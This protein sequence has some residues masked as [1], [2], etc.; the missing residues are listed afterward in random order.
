MRKAFILLV[1]ISACISHAQQRLLDNEEL[2]KAGAPLSAVASM[3]G[4]PLYPYLQYRA[5]R[6]NLA[7]TPSS[8]ISTFLRAHPTA[9]FSGWL[10]ERAFPHWLSS[11]QYQTIIE[12]YDP[13]FAD[14]SIECE[15]RLAQLA[16]GNQ[17]AA[18]NGINDLWQKASSIEAACDPLFA[19]AV[20]SGKLTSADIRNR[21]ILTMREGN[22]G[23][24]RHISTMLPSDG[25]LAANIWLSIVSGNAPY[26]Q[27]MTITD[28]FWQQSALVNALS[29]QAFKD[30]NRVASMAFELNKPGIADPDLEA[31]LYNRLT[32]ALASNNDPRATQ[33]WARIPADM[34]EDNTAYDMV[35]YFLRRGD[36]QSIVATF[37]QGLASKDNNPEINYWVGKAYEKLGNQRNSQTYYQKAANKRDFFGFLAAEKLGQSY[38]FN[39]HS[40]TRDIGIEQALLSEPEAYRMRIFQN[41]G[42][43]SRAIN[44]WKSLIKNKTNAQIRQAAL[45]ADKY[46]WHIHAISTLAKEKDWDA[47]NVRFP[48]DYEARVRAL[49]TKHALSPATIYAIIR[50]ESIFQPTIKSPAG[51]LGLMQV[52]PA[53]ARD[54][55]RRYNIPYGGTSQ[56]TNVDTNLTIGSQ[57]LADRLREFGH[58]GYAA[59]AYNAGPHRARKW[60]AEY[61]NLPLDEWIAQIPFNETRDYVKRVL[62][63]EKVYQ[64]RLGLNYTPY[65]SA[66]VRAW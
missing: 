29:R 25:I 6:D 44:E 55:A 62:E 2:V 59:A 53:T 33:T 35:A 12:T 23:V 3:Q 14:E 48:T 60:L 37:A 32:R 15:Y 21:F 40:I 13:R 47:L 56:L 57:Y 66:T 1:S 64:Y 11:R 28:P 61:P 27:A 54:T 46:G 9:P 19:A 10:A 65:S 38:A 31:Q 39:D 16:S 51:A 5:Y 7:T 49:A 52:M 45:L 30:T 26:Q 42:M 8:V 20:R 24:A 22:Y 18:F 41:M 17:Q 34:Q 58:L 50:K 36:W 63:Y 43:E 4:H